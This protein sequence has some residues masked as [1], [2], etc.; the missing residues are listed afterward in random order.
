M[1]GL[2]ARLSARR[3]ELVQ[4]PP[5]ARD[6]GAN[7]APPSDL[8]GQLTAILRRR[9]YVAAAHVRTKLPSPN[10]NPTIY[11]FL[12]SLYILTEA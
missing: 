6:V 5:R 12:W 11:F 2:A 7:M 8:M 1:N 10:K 3:D 4:P 9:D